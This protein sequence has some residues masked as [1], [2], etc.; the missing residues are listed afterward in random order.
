[1]GSFTGVVGDGQGV[2]REL[3]F[4]SSR[5]V[6]WGE[7]LLLV[8]AW[9]LHPVVFQAGHELAASIGAIGGSNELKP[10]RQ[11]GYGLRGVGGSGVLRTQGREVRISPC[12]GTWTCLLA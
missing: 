2:C 6:R 10:V 7:C 8:P 3:Q 4:E 11:P 5:W 1:M 9:K 12:L